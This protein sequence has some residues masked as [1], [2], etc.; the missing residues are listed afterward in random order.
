VHRGAGPSCATP[1]PANEEIAVTIPDSLLASPD[2]IAVFGVAV[3]RPGSEEEL[4]RGLLGLV[5]P[6]RREQGCLY[7]GVWLDS[8]TVG[9]VAY[10]EH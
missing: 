6:S 5:E 4:L 7:Y 1:T 2:P 8:V 9:G 3:A 10:F